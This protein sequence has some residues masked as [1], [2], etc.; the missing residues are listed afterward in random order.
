MFSSRDN[1]CTLSIVL[2]KTCLCST[3]RLDAT[4]CPIL[5]AIFDQVLY[6][7]PLIQQ[8]LENQK[9][10]KL[11]Y[12]EGLVWYGAIL[13]PFVQNLKKLLANLTLK[14]LS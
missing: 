12:A 7:L 4:K 10:A 1:K 6:C 5:S 2:E 14:F 9:I 3:D 8:F 13:G 11:R